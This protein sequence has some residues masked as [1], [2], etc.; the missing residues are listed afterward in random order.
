MTRRYARS[1]RGKRACDS[2]PVN[3]GPNVTTIGA[4][5]SQGIVAVQVVQGGTTLPKFHAFL[6]EL[7]PQLDKNDVVYL[8]NLSTH[9]SVS[10]RQR[11]EATGAQ[12]RF[13]P[14]YS[15]EYNPIE[16]LWSWMK[17]MLRA[18]A[19]R[20]RPTLYVAIISA[21]FLA[22]KAF[23]PAWIKHCGYR[24]VTP[25]YSCTPSFLGR[26]TGTWESTNSK[27]RVRSCEKQRSS[28]ASAEQLYR[29]LTLDSTSKKRGR[30]S[31]VRE[32]SF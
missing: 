7:C 9:R 16:M 22:D 32:P 26:N 15:P 3:H 11:V 19:P 4:M 23:F 30:I 24:L 14:P 31:R 13:L 8:D 1:L 12:L 25:S 10:V 28:S 21:C 17:T 5:C 20:S 27:Q 6:N 29:I 2:V 18:L